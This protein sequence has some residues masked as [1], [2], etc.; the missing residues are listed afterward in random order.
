[1]NTPVDLSTK[2]LGHHFI[3]VPYED[4]V[5][6]FKDLDSDGEH[7]LFHPPSGCKIDIL[8]KDEQYICQIG[9]KC[10]LTMKLDPWEEN[11]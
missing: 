6:L 3:I 4:D 5:Y 9:T 10:D 11:H 2:E 8:P 1:M 7:R